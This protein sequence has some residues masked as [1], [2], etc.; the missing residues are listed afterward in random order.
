VDVKVVRWGN[1]G[2]GGA[3]VPS[4]TSLG[5]ASARRIEQHRADKETLEQ[6]VRYLAAPRKP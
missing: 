5:Y 3:F 4:T 2:L 6:F 1:D